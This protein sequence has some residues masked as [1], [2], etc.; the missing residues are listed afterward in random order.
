MYWRALSSDQN[1]H[2]IVCPGVGIMYTPWVHEIPRK[3]SSPNEV[4]FIN[5][6]N[7][8]ACVFREPPLFPWK[9]HQKSP[10]RHQT[11]TKPPRSREK[12]GGKITKITT[13]TFLDDFCT[14]YSSEGS[15]RLTRARELLFF[16]LLY[17]ERSIGTLHSRFSP[18]HR[19]LRLRHHHLV[20][21][22]HQHRLSLISHPPHPE[23]RS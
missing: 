18:C 17:T 11:V 15:D 12:Q 14:F 13:P 6:N 21:P 8:E 16:L 9:R 23:W 22:Q 19:P 4:V 7:A 20:L 3:P 1:G 10:K 5:I 2:P